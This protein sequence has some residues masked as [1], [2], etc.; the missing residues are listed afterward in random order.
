MPFMPLRPLALDRVGLPCR[1]RAGR[2]CHC[3]H[4][5]IPFQLVPGWGQL[6]SIVSGRGFHLSCA[7]GRGGLCYDRSSLPGGDLPCLW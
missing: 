7:L 2:L 5:S 6:P 1:F 4:P 3:K